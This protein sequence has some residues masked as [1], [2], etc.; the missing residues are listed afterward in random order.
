VRNSD[1]PQFGRI[2][3]RS[4]TVKP[5]QMIERQ[6]VIVRTPEKKQFENNIA[7]LAAGVPPRSAVSVPLGRR[8]RI[9]KYSLSGLGI[10]DLP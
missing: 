4:A 3:H 9:V 8:S 7:V 10:A 1:D 6:T 5:A 2:G